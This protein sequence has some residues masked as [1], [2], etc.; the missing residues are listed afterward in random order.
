MYDQWCG[1]LKNFQRQV[2][3][4]DTHT[5]PVIRDWARSLS[6]ELFDDPIEQDKKKK[7]MYN[8]VRLKT[9]R[10]ETY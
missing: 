3:F 10:L 1:E 4:I 9:I 6:A 5:Q 7:I 2:H 8:V